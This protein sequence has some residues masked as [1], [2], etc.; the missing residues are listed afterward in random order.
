MK[1]ILPLLVMGCA[2]SFATGNLEA[3]KISPQEALQRISASQETPKRLKSGVSRLVL[4]HTVMTES[5]DEEAVYVFNRYNSKGYLVVSADDEFPAVLGYSDSGSFDSETMPPALKW[6]LS[7]YAREI[8]SFRSV[9]GDMSLQTESAS[10]MEKTPIEPLIKSQWN[11]DAP[12]NNLCPPVKNGAAELSATGCVATAM[13]QIMYYHKWPETGKGSYSYEYTMTDKTKNNLSLD[14]SQVRFDWGNMLDRYD[15]GSYNDEQ[16][17]AVAELMYACGVSV[18]ASY[19]KST[20]ANTVKDVVALCEYFGYSKEMRYLY[21]EYT[22]SSI[23]WENVIYESLSKKSPVIYSGAS[24]AGG[25]SFICD[26]YSGDGYYH[27]NWGWAGSSDGY[28][29]L[30]LLNPSDQGIGGSG[31]G[32]NDR[33]LIIYNI[34]PAKEGETADYEPGYM[35]YKGDFSFG[36][37]VKSSD[38]STKDNCFHVNDHGTCTGFYNK[39]PYNIQLR[40]GLLAYDKDGNE[41]ELFLST[42]KDYKYNYGSGWFTIGSS[43]LQNTLTEGDYTIYPGYRL[44]SEEKPRKMKHTNGYRDHLIMRYAGDGTFEIIDPKPEKDYY[45]QLVVS[46]F[47]YQGNVYQNSAHNFSMTFGN[48]SV[49]KDYYGDI[50]MIVEDEN[51]EKVESINLVQDIP[52]NRTMSLSA[53]ISFDLVPGS[54]K[55]RFE[56]PAGTRFLGDYSLIISKGSPEVINEEIQF[57]SM[58]PVTFEPYTNCEKIT[59]TMRNA[60]KRNLPAPKYYLYIYNLDGSFVKGWSY[61]FKNVFGKGKTTNYGFSNVKLQL[62]PGEYYIRYQWDKPSETGSETTKVKVTP[63]IFISVGYPVENVSFENDIVEVGVGSSLDLKA[64]VEP[65]KAAE[66][67]TLKWTSEDPSIVEVDSNGKVNAL[68]D[69]ETKVFA[70][71]PNGCYAMCKVKVGNKTA[72]NDILSSGAEIIAVYNIEGML[73]LDKPAV[74]EMNNLAK[75][76]YIVK[77]NEGTF[78]VVK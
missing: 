30:H 16:A 77:T 73:I 68:K 39:S 19:A 28:F 22:R 49:E 27:F 44:L 31:A 76:I 64:I 58:S 25:H 5:T 67:N 54:Y 9:E 59:L 75:G 71:A 45:P 60:G 20:S 4:G 2:F 42:D 51:G 40:Y 10:S 46:S 65:E 43:T 52:A 1:R 24:D 69:G 66:T 15:E 35:G 63:K 6:W 26:G 11:Q 32:Y 36:T 72:V 61:T 34:H 7:E 48:L 23:E 50:L 78:K 38:G 53:A 47:N 3:K 33:Q 13:A 41:F 18:E 74:E 70:F 37:Y 17:K 57:V 14:F 56:S 62:D 12:Y 29:L 8:E 55:V 21:R